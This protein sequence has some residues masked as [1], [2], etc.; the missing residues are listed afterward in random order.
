MYC[1]NATGHFRQ[2]DTLTDVSVS[3]YVSDVS[4]G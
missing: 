3:V 4:V 1:N 2:S